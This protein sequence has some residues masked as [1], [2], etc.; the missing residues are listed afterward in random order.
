MNNNG[1]APPEAAV[2]G[3]YQC[4][5]DLSVADCATCVVSAAGQLRLICA[6]A[7]SAVLQLDGCLVRYGN[8]NFLGRP[9]TTLVH[10]RCNS[11]T[12]A[13]TEFFRRRDDVLGDLQN[14]VGFR[15]S[16]S[17]SVEGYGQ[18]LGDL[19]SGDCAACLAAA[20]SQLKNACGSALAADVFLGQCYARYWA[21]GYYPNS[22]QGG[23]S[24]SLS[25]S[26]SLTHHQFGS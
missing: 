13:D 8:D 12:T 22:S 16:S 20:V 24:L 25:L 18:C 7:F 5:N 15:V 14:G 21:S 4:R 26:L 11:D 1:T 9:D 2:Y 3:L 19:S 6:Y 23:F 10:R 17:G